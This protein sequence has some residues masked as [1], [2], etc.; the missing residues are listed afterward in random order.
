M[1]VIPYLYR[2]GRRTVPGGMVFTVLWLTGRIKCTFTCKEDKR[3]LTINHLGSSH[4]LPPPRFPPRLGDGLKWM[5]IKKKKYVKF[6]NYIYDLRGGSEQ[7][8]TRNLCY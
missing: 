8:K 5:N 7:N 1:R 2:A 6:R 4:P 3:K